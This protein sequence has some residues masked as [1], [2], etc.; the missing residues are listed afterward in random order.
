MGTQNH[1]RPHLI[2]TII[3]IMT[4]PT[5][6][7]DRSRHRCDDDDDIDRILLEARPTLFEVDDDDDAVE[8]ALGTIGT[9]HH[10]PADRN[11][12][13]AD[14]KDGR[15]KTTNNGSAK[16]KKN[17]I[18]AEKRRTTPIISTGGS[19]GSSSDAV[20]RRQSDEKTRNHS[21]SEGASTEAALRDVVLKTMSENNNNNNNNQE[22]EEEEDVEMGR[23]L[24]QENAEG[25]K[26]DGPSASAKSFGGSVDGLMKAAA[27]RREY[28]PAMSE[29][30]S[31]DMNNSNDNC[32][33]AFDLDDFMADFVPPEMSNVLKESDAQRKDRLRRNREAAQLS[34]IA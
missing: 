1:P 8:D 5:P 23:S 18:K 3:I 21:H 9:P 32:F 26:N 13:R 20:A 12:Q 2:I 4:T 34:L 25:E 17:F 33:D 11:R 31:N 29:N 27:A 16:K 15:G 10:P 22:E 6:P 24:R 28:R 7:P 14:G 19:D 30:Y